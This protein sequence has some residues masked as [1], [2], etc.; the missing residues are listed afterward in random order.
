MAT[1]TIIVPNY[2]HEFFLRERLESVFRQSYDDFEV[3]LLDDKSSDGSASVI[4][5]FHQKYSDKVAHCEINSVNS[6]SPFLQWEKGVSLAKGKY[7]W[8]AESD[9]VADL[10]FLD[11]TVAILEKED[12]VGVVSTTATF[13]D[14]EG[15]TQG[16]TQK[17]FPKNLK[18]DERGLFMQEG[19][20]FISKYMLSS[21]LIYNAS[22]VLFRRSLINDS[23]LDYSGF[24]QIGDVAFWINLILQAKVAIV[25]KDLNY[26]RKHKASVTAANY[27]QP[28]LVVSEH[29]TMIKLLYAKDEL[30][31][32]AYKNR[33]SE[34]VKKLIKRWWNLKGK[35]VDS[36]GRDDFSFLFNLLRHYLSF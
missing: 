32:K 9:D 7:I 27:N 13:I 10:S 6:G 31:R 23:L 24:R 20:E 5:E 35:R 18:F 25:K 12:T 2:N 14:E 21:N 19:R 1:V 33:K 30:F 22:G 17:W 26:W 15:N 34:T 28:S 11:Q 8:I 36:L 3:I 4:K 16:S 29:L